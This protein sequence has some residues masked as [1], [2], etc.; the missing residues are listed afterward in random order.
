MRSSVL[1]TRDRQSAGN[2]SGK[3]NSETA[4]RWLSR[5]RERLSTSVPSK[6]K[7]ISFTCLPSSLP[8]QARKDANELSRLHRNGVL[9]IPVLCCSGAGQLEIVSRGIDDQ[10]FRREIGDRRREVGNR[11]KPGERVQLRRNAG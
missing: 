9:G 6:S 4:S 11:R 8:V 1:P 10:A 7:M 2:G 5:I 3:P